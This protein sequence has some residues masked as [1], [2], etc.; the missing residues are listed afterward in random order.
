MTYGKLL[1]SGELWVMVY[2][3]VGPRLE[4]CNKNG[5]RLELPGD[6]PVLPVRLP[7]WRMPGASREG[8]GFLL[9][10]PK[11]GAQPQAGEEDEAPGGTNAGGETLKQASNLAVLTGEGAER[12]DEDDGQDAAEHA[13]R[14]PPAPAGFDGIAAGQHEEANGDGRNGHESEDLMDRRVQGRRGEGHPSWRIACWVLGEEPI[15]D[16]G[17][18]L[19]CPQDRIPRRAR[20]AFEKDAPGEGG[21]DRDRAE[22]HKVELLDPSTRPQA[23]CADG[24]LPGIV[25]GAGGPFDQ[26]DRRK[27]EGTK[28]STGQPH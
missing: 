20:A 25:V 11:G 16:E 10:A 23:E 22:D 14:G 28:C 13:V 15:D 4:T 5:T 26:I 9:E 6:G 2:Q 27:E 8:R 17:Q 24:L 1:G 19:E 18:S 21:P 3:G 12:R 7:L